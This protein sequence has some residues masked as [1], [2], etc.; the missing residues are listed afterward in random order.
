MQNPYY[1]LPVIQAP[2]SSGPYTS[3]AV[4][5]PSSSSLTSGP[6]LRS[7]ASAASSRASNGL[8]ISHLIY[9]SGQHDPEYSRPA[10]TYPHS[11][12]SLL[13]SPAESSGLFPESRHQNEAVSG[14]HMVA[15]NQQPHKRAYRQRRKDPSCDACRE[16]KVKV[17]DLERQL[18]QAKQQ[19]CQLRSGIPKTDSLMDPAFDLHED[20]P[21]IPE[22]GQRPHRLNNSSNI[23]P[24][25]SHV[26]WKMRTYGQGLI[27]FPPAS[28]FTH[29]QILLTRDVPSLPPATIVD[30]LLENYFSH[31]HRVFPIVHWPT[32]LSDNDRVSRIGSFSGAPREWVAM[33]F[34]M[35]ACGSLHSLDQEL[36]LKGKDFLQ[37]S[38]SLIDVWQ[39]AFSLDQVRT[40][41]LIS[42]FLYETNLK[43]ASWVW[44]GSAVKMAQDLGL[45]IESG[46]SSM[47][48]EL[49]KRVWWA[50]YAWER[51]ARY[52]LALVVI[53]TGRPLTIHDEDCD[54]ELPSA[55]EQLT[56]GGPLPHDEKPTFL[57]AISHV[58]RAVSQLT[59]S[60]K[61]PMIS[62]D[63]LEAFERHFRMCLE[64][65]PLDYR[66]EANHYLDPR[67][68]PPII[69]L[70]NTRLILHRHN[71][72]PRSSMEVRHVALG[73]CLAIARDTACL[74]SR[75]M[76][77][78]NSAKAAFNWRYLIA[79]AATTILCCHIWRCT[80]ILLL[81][82]DYAG[83]LV[84]V[85]VSAAI[86]DGRPANAAC[87]RYVAFF[88]KILLEKA[89]RNGVTNQD[90]DEEIIAYVSGD[91]QGRI[92]GSWIWQTD[93]NEPPSAIT[94]PQSSSSSKASTL[95]RQFV[96]GV[97]NGATPDVPEKEWEGWGWIEQTIQFLL[98]EQ[99]R[100]TVIVETKDNETRF[101][102]P[103]RPNVPS[104]RP[105]E[106]TSPVRNSPTSHSLMTIANII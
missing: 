46:C 8:K 76:R 82:G 102:G 54:V 13:A 73:R 67:S 58:M 7:T 17:Q 66:M 32:F 30:T 87:G 62:A 50:L 18:I 61:A 53:E 55:N 59:K 68:L 71:L 25:P 41:M 84:C 65:F 10:M 99:Q 1:Q 103:V 31:L 11:Q 19:L 69:F 86:G 94:P 63:T 60:L 85:Q 29:P 75:C 70:Q 16:R 40:V 104:N 9:G 33:V 49:R 72:S 95:G 105:P 56:N 100:Q 88:L 101:S 48:A 26:R 23:N 39:D 77:F 78:P 79:G 45:H 20:T 97:R 92:S 89:Q 34:A 98:T 91:L 5:S 4:S 27:N 36:V 15:I 93:E 96:D 38:V 47:E 57:L 81:R 90:H 42:I 37:T 14:L 44:L 64:T 21:R 3:L 106:N 6:Q 35:L 52:Q 22:V 80:L 43:S 12:E 2:N 51:S 28:P 74:L 24:P 83:A